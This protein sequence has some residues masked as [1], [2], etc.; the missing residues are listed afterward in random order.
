MSQFDV[1]LY[2][3]R[4]NVAYLSA[5]PACACLF[6]CNAQAG[7]ADRSKQQASKMQRYTRVCVAS[8][9][10]SDVER[11]VPDE[12]HTARKNNNQIRLRRISAFLPPASWEVSSRGLL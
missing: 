3:A 8:E 4:D 5:S 11:F 7:E 2:S 6:A 1:A 9:L 10:V 12:V